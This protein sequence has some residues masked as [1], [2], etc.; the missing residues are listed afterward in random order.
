MHTNLSFLPLRE[1][2]YELEREKDK[3]SDQIFAAEKALQ[4][5]GRK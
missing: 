4:Q 1:H 3:L 2:I 5:D